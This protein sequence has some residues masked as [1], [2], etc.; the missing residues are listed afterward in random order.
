MQKRQLGF[1]GPLVPTI[2]LGCAPMSGNIPDPARDPRG[3]ETIRAAIDAGLALLDT[4]DFY[5]NGHNEELI[6]RSLRPGDRERVVIS[7]KFGGLRDPAGKFV[8]IDARPAYLKSALGYSLQRL[9]TD[10]IDIYRP[11]RL[12]P[13]VPIEETVGALREMIEAGWVRHIG[14]SEVGSETIR[15]AHAVHPITDVQIEYSLFNR[16]AEREILGTCRELGIGV[17]AYGVLAHGLLTG[18]YTG[19][20]EIRHLPQ[21]HGE[22]LAINLA[23]VEKLRPIADARGITV[24]QLAIAWVLAQGDHIVPLVGL[25]RPSRIAAAQQAAALTLTKEELAAIDEAVPPGAVAGTRYAAPLM[26]MLDS[27]R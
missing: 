9:G 12:D 14:L 11:C 20:P 2:G 21:H 3:I 25:S 4:A 27:E 18:S 26:G 13:A 5:G 10:H 23:L 17:T 24:A 19:D 8:G 1:D 6:R 22:N 16:G 7:D 15:R